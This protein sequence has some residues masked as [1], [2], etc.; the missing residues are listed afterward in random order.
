MAFSVRVPKSLVP[1]SPLPAAVALAGFA[2]FAGTLASGTVFGDPTEYTLVPHLWGILHPPGYP[3]M[4][5]LV[6]LWQTL[7]PIGTLAYRTNLLSSAAGA[8]TGALVFG[9]MMPLSPLDPAQ[10]PAADG[11]SQSGANPVSARNGRGRTFRPASY[12]NQH[13]S[14]SKIAVANPAMKQRS[15]SA[16]EHARYEKARVLRPA[17]A[18]AIFRV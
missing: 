12:S 16:V 5:L 1:A 10:S 9:M 2:L 17:S 13:D 11:S 7:M 18:I 6:K 15:P 4:T 3:F 8:A 14:L